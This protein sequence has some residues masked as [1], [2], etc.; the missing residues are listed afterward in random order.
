[1]KEVQEVIVE[2]CRVVEKEKVSFHTNFEEDKA[3]IH[4]EKEQLL[5]EQ[6]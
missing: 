2:Q 3:Q 4:Q 6:L 1:L 5:T